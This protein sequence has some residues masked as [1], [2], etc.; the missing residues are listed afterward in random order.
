MQK[1]G[2]TKENTGEPIKKTAAQL[3]RTIIFKYNE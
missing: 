1:R 3:D 2:G